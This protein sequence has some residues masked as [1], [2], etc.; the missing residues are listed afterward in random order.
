MKKIFYTL[1]LLAPLFTVSLNAAYVDD[2]DLAD[3]LLLQSQSKKEGKSPK[4]PKDKEALEKK[5]PKIPQY[6][7]RAPENEKE[8][9]AA[10]FLDYLKEL[11]DLGQKTAEITQGKKAEGIITEARKKKEQAEK[12]F[13]SKR[14]SSGSS[15]YSS[16]GGG[17]GYS[18]G[19]GSR[20]SSWGGGGRGGSWG[21]G[22][23]GGSGSR[24]WKPSSKDYSSDY[25]PRSSG[26]RG[27]RGVSRGGGR[28][29]YNR[30][31]DDDDETEKKNVGFRSPDEAKKPLTSKN[32]ALSLQKTIIDDLKKI[33]QG[34]KEFTGKDQKDVKG[35][36]KAQGTDENY[37]QATLKGS[38]L[39]NLANHLD[40]QKK[41]LSELSESE[42]KK[43]TE[44]SEWTS[45]ETEAYEKAIPALVRSATYLPLDEGLP[46]AIQT[47]EYRKLS[48]EQSQAKNILGVKAME[49]HTDKIK[50]EVNNMAEELYK[51]YEKIVQ[52]KIKIVQPET[53]KPTDTKAPAPAPKPLTKVQEKAR[54]NAREALVKIS[55][56]LSDFEKNFRALTKGPSKLQQLIK[57]M[58]GIEEEQDLEPQEDK[59][60]EAKPKTPVKPPLERARTI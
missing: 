58:E 38:A 6:A 8:K 3:E 36:K 19:R 53:K 48:H 51:K 26:S 32:R 4:N 46:P 29:G 55:K 60:T 41:A 56:V 33:T 47:E 10:Q 31:H 28:S 52:E 16:G 7:R 22:G 13:A 27:G 49:K 12:A 17:R 2:T 34:Y 57:T 50:Q 43:L 35:A 42:Q 30:D 15:R 14:K 11:A 45:G 40:Q 37:A 59:K 9:V 20:G 24:G 21:S 5:S 54:D 44:S 18:G 23:R 25:S 39:S 1:T